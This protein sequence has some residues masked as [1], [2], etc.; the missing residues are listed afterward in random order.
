M[1]TEIGYQ[2]LNGEND[3]ISLLTMWNEYRKMTGIYYKMQTF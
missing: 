2:L 3:Y 1:Y